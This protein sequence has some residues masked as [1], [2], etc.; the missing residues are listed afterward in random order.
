MALALIVA[1]LLQGAAAVPPPPAAVPPAR[2]VR[3]TLFI[4][5]SGE[6]FRGVRGEAYPVATWFARADA[7][8][9]GRLTRNEFRRDFLLFF[10]VLDLNGDGII[11][12]SE[13]T[14]YEETLVPEVRV[15]F[16]SGPEFQQLSGGAGSGAP[17]G[18][19]GEEPDQKPSRPLPDLPR[20]GGR[21]S[22]INAPEPVVSMDTDLN[23]R[24]SPQE[25][26][27]AADRRFSLLDPDERGYLTLDTL[28]RT[29]IQ[30]RGQGDAV[31][32]KRR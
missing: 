30:A 32:K 11:D 13:I 16:G 6:P 23:R 21:Y 17:L 24:I 1:T 29:P 9:D 26:A 19:D 28:P 14:R 2:P 20:G 31:P 22:L 12:A 18:G 4:A 8:H 3:G 5:P 27:A 7:D 15:G 10:K 25:F